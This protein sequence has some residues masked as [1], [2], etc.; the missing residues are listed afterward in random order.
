MMHYT[1]VGSRETPVESGIILEALVDMLATHHYVGRSGGADGADSALEYQ[2]RESVGLKEIYLPWQSFNGREADGVEYIN[3]STMPN[4]KQA[5]E[6][7]KATH[8]AWDKCSQGAQKLHARNVYQVLGKDLASPSSVLICWAI[9]TAKGVRG[10][11][12]TAVQ[13]AKANHVPVLNIHGMD[14]T[15]ALTELRNILT[16]V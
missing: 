3:A 5:M 4:Y 10:G 8:P 6:I 1:L 9:P 11:T 13:L 12:N 15:T 14:L 7:A 16:G 2:L